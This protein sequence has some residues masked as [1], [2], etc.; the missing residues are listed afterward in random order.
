MR[1]E[2]VEALSTTTQQNIYPLHPTITTS[3]NKIITALPQTILQSTVIPSFI[4]KKSHSKT[5]AIQ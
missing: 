2:I 4:L 3:H 5:L 1:D